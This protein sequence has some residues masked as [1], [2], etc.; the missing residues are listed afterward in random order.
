ME[1]KNQKDAMKITLVYYFL[2]RCKKDMPIATKGDWYRMCRDIAS[3]TTWYK[4]FELLES[5]EAIILTRKNK[6]K[7]SEKGMKQFMKED[8][9]MKKVDFISQDL[10]TFVIE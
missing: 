1:E 5:Y 4:F 9:L 8:E 3:K 6:Y 10:S 7:Y 2:Q